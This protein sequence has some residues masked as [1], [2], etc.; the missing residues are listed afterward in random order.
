MDVKATA[1]EDSSRLDRAFQRALLLW[2]RDEYPKMAYKI[3]KSLDDDDER[4]Y[5]NLFYLQEHDLCK[6]L[7]SQSAD[8][9][10]SWGRST[11]NR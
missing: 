7:T 3:P 10:I 8:G 1:G 2:M 4:F 6:A 5:F 11:N 9:H